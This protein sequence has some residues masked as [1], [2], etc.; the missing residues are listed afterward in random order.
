MDI[1]IRNSKLEDFDD[2]ILLFNQLWPGKEL[3]IND[4]MVVFSRG[5]Q[6]DSD[7]LLCVEQNGKVIGFCSFA[8]VNNF[9]Q[10][11]YIAYVYA[12]IIDDSF[13]GR[14]IG[15]ELLKKAFDKAKLRG[16]K[17][18]ELDSGFQREKA[19]KFYEKIGFTKRAYLFSKDL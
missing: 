12:M 11:G 7:E 19:H 15:T 5:I 14:G 8:I 16:C 4:L 1:I 2:V 13:R 3:N 17:K 10:E 9:W 18:I 6:S